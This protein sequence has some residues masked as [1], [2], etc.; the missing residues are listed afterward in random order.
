MEYFTHLSKDK[1]LKK[2]LVSP[3]PL[4][5]VH[6]HAPLRLMQSIMSQ[7]LSVKVAHVLHER[8]YHLCGC[9]NPPLQQ[10]CDLDPLKLRAIG[11]SH[12]KTSYIHNV[13]RFCLEN[14]ITDRRLR[15]MPSEEIIELLTAI[16][17]V[18]RWTVEMLLMFTLAREDI[19]AADDLGIQLAMIS[20][21][22]LKRPEKPN[23]KAFKSRLAEI[24]A[25]WSPYRTY[26]CMH[27][28][29]FKDNPPL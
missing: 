24:S 27:L 17:G 10:I 1:R 11:L 18:G 8:F 28:W 9:K 25:K 21:Y 22:G 4:L 19:F 12:A 14:K 15:S 2:A 7:Q 26:G 20:L 23:D 5:R 13:A 16:K 29:A 6:P 3:L